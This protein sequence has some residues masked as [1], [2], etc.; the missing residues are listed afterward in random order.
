MGG[1]ER[2]MERW[3]ERAIKRAEGWRMEEDNGFSPNEYTAQGTFTG[4]DSK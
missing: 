3:R 1:E 4:K 2:E